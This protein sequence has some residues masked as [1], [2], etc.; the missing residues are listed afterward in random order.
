MKWSVCCLQGLLQTWSW[1]LLSFMNEG[2]FA[3][4]VLWWLLLVLISVQLNK[5][6]QKRL[7]FMSFIVFWCFFDSFLY[8]LHIL[9]LQS[10]VNENDAFYSDKSDE[11][12]ITCCFCWYLSLSLI[13]FWFFTLD[14]WWVF[15]SLWHFLNKITKRLIVKTDP[16]WMFALRQPQSPQKTKARVETQSKLISKF[17]SGEGL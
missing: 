13:S 8:S 11:T 15:F 9:V 4:L 12:L 10:N 16:E 6:L 14:L 5:K 3:F 1:S 2:G 17:G 7:S